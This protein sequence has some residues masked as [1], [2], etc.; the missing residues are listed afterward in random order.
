MQTLLGNLLL[1]TQNIQAAALFSLVLVHIVQSGAGCKLAGENAE[2]RQFTNI[3]IGNGLENES[4]ERLIIC[5]GPALRLA[6]LGVEAFM[7]NA[8]M[9]RRRH[10]L[11][12]QVHH[13]CDTNTGCCRNRNHGYNGTILHALMESQKNIIIGE[14]FTFKILHHEIII[15]SSSLF[16]KILEPAIHFAAHF[17]RHRDFLALVIASLIGFLF[18]NV[19]DAAETRAITYRNQHRNHA[20][21]VTLTQLLKYFFKGNVLTV[22]LIYNEHTAVSML[23]SLLECLLCTNTETGNCTYNDTN[24]FDNTNR[25]RNFAGKIEIAWNVN[26]IEHFAIPVNRCCS[27]RNR[28]MTLNLFRLKVGSRITVFHLALAINDMSGVEHC[29]SQR[30]LALAA[31]PHERYI[32]DIGRYII[33]HDNP[34][35]AVCIKAFQMINPHAYLSKLYMKCMKKKR[36]YSISL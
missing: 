36:L 6:R 9:R 3:R 10:V 17:S 25:S 8:Q 27:S 16:G 14:F 22:H 35:Y 24:S 34:P 31:M 13:T 4:G 30:G 28:A 7:G 23:Y 15:S 19:H 33:C 26:D 29:L 32:P 11:G 2:Q 21:A 1:A 5:A 12:H 20:G 18:K